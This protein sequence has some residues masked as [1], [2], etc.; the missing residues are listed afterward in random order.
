MYYFP[1]P[2]EASEDGLLAI[3]GDLREDRLLLAY[4]YGIFPWYDRPPIL[5]WFTSPRCVVFP[6]K[7]RV[8]KSMRKLLRDGEFEVS[9]NREFRE[10]MNQCASANR[11]NQS[12]T[13]IDE[14]MINAYER[15]HQTGVA[16][17]VEV[18]KNGNLAGGLYGIALG[19]IFYGESMFAIQSNA[20]KFGFIKLCDRLIKAGFFLIDCQQTTGHM[21]SLGAEMIT[22]EQFWGFLR[23]NILEKTNPAIFS[24]HSDE[25]E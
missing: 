23:R 16:H 7:V 12:S 20:S 15:L 25:I 6:D 10:V 5:W 1:H 17:S 18:W 13:W 3:G 8:S 2:F 21:I 14:D 24:D 4:Q 22:R 9:F 19:K 11:K